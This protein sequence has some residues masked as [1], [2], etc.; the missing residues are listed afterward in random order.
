[1]QDIRCYLLPRTL[2]DRGRNLLANKL[3]PDCAQP[4]DIVA[5]SG[6]HCNGGDECN[7]EA[8]GTE[9]DAASIRVLELIICMR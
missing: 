2:T 6:A 8:P 7:H 5:Q 1:M 4:V 9:G 3:L